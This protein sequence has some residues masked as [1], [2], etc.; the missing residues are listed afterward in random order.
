MKTVI[1]TKETAETEFDYQ[2]LDYYRLFDNTYM[3]A[4]SEAIKSY[5]GDYR[6]ESL[7]N[8]TKTTILLFDTVE[9]RRLQAM[10]DYNRVVRFV[11]DGSVDYHTILAASMIDCFVCFGARSAYKL[12]H[13]L[14]TMK[15]TKPVYKI[16]P[17]T[18][19]AGLKVYD[20]APFGKLPG[21]GDMDARG[22]FRLMAAG[23]I[24]IV[25]DVSPFN[26]II[27]DRWNGIV[28]GS[29]YSL[30]N[31]DDIKTISKLV[32]DKSEIV[33]R[34]IE[35][36]KLALSKERYIARFNHVISGDG[37]DHN[38][39]WV[40]PIVV[41]K[42]K[43]IIPKEDGE[44]GIISRTPATYHESFKEMQVLPL[45]R[46]LNYLVNMP[47]ESVYV[48]DAIIEE[49]DDNKV[50]IINR[51]VTTLGDRIKDVHFCFRSPPEWS[52][53]SRLSFLPVEEGAKQ[54]S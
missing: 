20:N 37:F 26:E 44:S 52:R 25:P 46:L 9:P 31:D 11:E 24:V 42:T 15:L 14:R 16:A 38:E 29:D 22:M 28:L 33:N 50:G 1:V 32:R 5:L 18:D 8:L 27:V 17:W 10:G 23:A 13:K 2:A 21:T 4:R 6:T 49:L 36:A 45:D 54:V 47:F 30:L 34:S 12:A 35:F 3:T 40:E 41:R 43:W 53:I 19:T 48:F 51:A 7:D 39:P